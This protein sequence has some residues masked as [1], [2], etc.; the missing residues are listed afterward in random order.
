MGISRCH[1]YQIAK[2]NENKER[3]KGGRE[4]EREEGK[5]GGRKEGVYSVLVSV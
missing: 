1:F 3:R 4:G 2:R 5:K